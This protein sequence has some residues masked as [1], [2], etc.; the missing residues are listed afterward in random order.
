MKQYFDK[1]IMPI[2]GTLKPKLIGSRALVE[3]R[4]LLLAPWNLN[5]LAPEHMLIKGLFACEKLD[6]DDL[7]FNA[8]YDTAHV[9]EKWFF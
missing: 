8:F 9:D 3:Q 1:A 4:T 5:C 6:P 7:M 2:T